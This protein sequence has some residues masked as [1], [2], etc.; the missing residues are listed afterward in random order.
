MSNITDNKE[1]FLP[2]DVMLQSYKQG[3]KHHRYNIYVSIV[4]I[5]TDIFKQSSVDI[6]KK[7]VKIIALLSTEYIDVLEQSPLLAK[8][9]SKKIDDLIINHNM[10]ELIPIYN[11]I[12]TNDKYKDIQSQPILLTSE[13][14]DILL[15]E[16][17]APIPIVTHDK[18]K[19]AVGEIIGAK[20]K[21]GNWWMSEVLFSTS[22]NTHIIYY[23]KFLNWGDQF[24]EFIHEKH[25]M[26]RFN[27]FK[28][29]YYRTASELANIHLES[30]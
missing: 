16:Y 3:E 12:Y 14:T 1:E 19:Y 10:I 8:S 28:H 26:Q 20:D 17:H 15:A 13:I 29:K 5:I 18:P 7:C 24:N 2:N 27:P 22:Y 30:D 4:E 23:I 9:L 25:R 21:E 6:K 11:L